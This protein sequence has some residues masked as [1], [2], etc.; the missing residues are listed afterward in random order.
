[1]S[2][3]P[4]QQLQTKSKKGSP[5]PG[6]PFSFS[7]GIQNIAP[8]RKAVA[9]IPVPREEAMTSWGASWIL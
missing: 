7:G 4:S 3:G 5:G 1:M 6:G 8:Q 9:A 2:F